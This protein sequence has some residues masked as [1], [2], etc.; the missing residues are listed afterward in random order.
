MASGGNEHR[1]PHGWW[2]RQPWLAKMSAGMAAVGAMVAAAVIINKPWQSVA[3]SPVAS[4]T[5]VRVAKPAT[6]PAEAKP[7][8]LGPVNALVAAGRFE[9]ALAGLSAALV[10]SPK[11]ASSL[12]LRGNVLQTLRRFKEAIDSYQQALEARPDVAA[13]QENLALSRRFLLENL[14]TPSPALSA[15][16]EELRGAMIRQG[17]P[18]EALAIA[19]YVTQLGPDAK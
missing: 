15:L 9:E 5:N 1:P 2:E 18:V 11:D 14:S 13:V 17:R 3:G 8:N 16:F 7:V 12:A 19:A 10:Q 6:A 4:E